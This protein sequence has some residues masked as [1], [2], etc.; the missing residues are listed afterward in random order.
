MLGSGLTA[1]IA[2]IHA[3]DANLAQ[4][5]LVE[6]RRQALLP[7]GLAGPLQLLG[8]DRGIV[9]DRAGSVDRFTLYSQL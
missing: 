1:A 8:I 4:L 2:E 6:L 9:E 3:V 7:L 5:H